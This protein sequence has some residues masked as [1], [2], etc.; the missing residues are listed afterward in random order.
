MNQTRTALMT[1]L[2]A[3]AVGA[4]AAETADSSPPDVRL[5]IDLRDGSR[6]V[7]TP[8]ASGLLLVTPYARLDIPFAHIRTASFDTAKETATVELRNGDSLSGVADVKAFSL[9]TS[10]GPATVD[11]A[12]VRGLTVRRQAAVGTDGL[13]LWCTFDS[14][15]DVE[16]ARAGAGGSHRAGTFVPGKFGQALSVSCADA[17][18]VT[19]RADVVNPKAGCIEFWAK[20]VDVP[21]ALAWGQNPTFVRIV[22][23]SQHPLML[24]L[25]GN[26]GGGFG[27]LCAAIAGIGRAGTGP[28]GNWTYAG[29]LGG[30]EAAD[31]HHYAMVWD[32]AGI[33]GVE[34]GTHK[35]ALY[36]DGVLNSRVWNDAADTPADPFAGGELRI[37]F[38]QHLA[39]GRVLFDDLRVWDHARTA[40]DA[41]TVERP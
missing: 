11:L 13:T 1:M 25:N 35:L 8:A 4:T 9:D 32:R 39:Q 21:S 37:M 34:N 5:A 23:G 26:D 24:Y 14:A 17:D 19:F 16:T 2:L 30:G 15:A 10:F 6:L 29:A 36:V 22:A 38:Q 31:W 12:L 20:L 3:A 33:P 41:E 40:F 7:G 18:A 28:Y 27:G